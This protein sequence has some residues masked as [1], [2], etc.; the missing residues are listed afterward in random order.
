[1][2]TKLKLVASSLWTLDQLCLALA[3]V[4]RDWPELREIR[5]DVS[6]LQ[7]LDETSVA[8][9][10]RAIDTTTAAGAELWFDGC[11]SRMASFLLARGVEVRRLGSLR[12]ASSESAETLH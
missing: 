8:S 5:V 1:M 6:G 11:D 3:A 10:T 12:A 9:V 7:T 4:L 2:R